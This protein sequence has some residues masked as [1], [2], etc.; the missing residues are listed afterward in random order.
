MLPHRACRQGVSG[1]V[2]QQ[3]H[4][5]AEINVI[6]LLVAQAFECC[7]RR[8]CIMESLLSLAKARAG[9]WKMTRATSLAVNGLPSFID[10]HQPLSL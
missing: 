5:C 7:S 6:L 9:Q 8:L 3:Q 2:L 4:R 1:R 10:F